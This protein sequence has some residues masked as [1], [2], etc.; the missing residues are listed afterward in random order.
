MGRLLSDSVLI[1]GFLAIVLAP[2]TLLARQRL[3]ADSSIKQSPCD[4]SGD[5][6]CARLSRSAEAFVDAG[7]S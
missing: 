2:L 5:A 1:I 6:G 4:G 7:H 3:T